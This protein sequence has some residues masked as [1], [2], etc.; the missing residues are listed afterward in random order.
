MANAA[1]PRARLRTALIAAALAVGLAS[2][3]RVDVRDGPTECAEADRVSVG[4]DVG[5]NYVGKIDES[6]ASGTPGAEFV[7]T[8]S[9]V[10]VGVGDLIDGWDVGLIGLCRGAK[11]VLVVPPE[12]AYGDAAMGDALPG[13]A[14][15]RFDIEVESVAVPPPDPDLFAELDADGD[16]MLTP[17]EILAHF[18][19]EGPDAEMPPDLMSNEDANGDGVVSRE[20]FGGPKMS[21]D[22]CLEMLH[23]SAKDADLGSGAGGPSALGLAVQWICWRPNGD[24]D[25]DRGAGSGGGDDD[26]GANEEL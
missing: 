14:T 21:R 10:T 17:D 11:A 7:S 8:Y 3:L 18:R 20:E 2:E 6:S 13:G 5:V 1:A 15:L 22:M 23:Q 19:K 26:K 24:G 9:D 16:G 25:I 12:M 4:S